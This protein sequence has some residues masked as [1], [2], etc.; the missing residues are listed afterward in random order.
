MHEICAVLKEHKKSKSH[1]IS[2][3]FL[4][5]C[6]SNCNLNFKSEQICPLGSSSVN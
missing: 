4:D 2:E 5:N 1:N 3:R 6:K